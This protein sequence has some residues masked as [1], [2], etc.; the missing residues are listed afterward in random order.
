MPDDAALDP[1]VLGATLAAH[2]RA[3]GLAGLDPG[4]R[5]QRAGPKRAA[6]LPP[7]EYVDQLD[8]RRRRECSL[9]HQHDFVFQ[10]H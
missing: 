9:R 2:S 1:A 3:V 10:F 8:R 5:R 6:A 7:V 4:D